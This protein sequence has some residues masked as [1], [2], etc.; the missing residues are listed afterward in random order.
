MKLVTEIYLF[1]GI[2][3]ARLAILEIS[4]KLFFACGHLI[5]QVY[6]N[7]LWYEWRGKTPENDKDY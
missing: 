5:W 4:F 7:F 2:P 6:G 3:T 1:L